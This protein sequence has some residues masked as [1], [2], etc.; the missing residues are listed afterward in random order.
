M[1]T[2]LRENGFRLQVVYRKGGAY[3]AAAHDIEGKLAQRFG[4]A[5]KELG[6]R[7]L[8]LMRDHYAVHEITETARIQ[9][10]DVLSGDDAFQKA[11]ETLPGGEPATAT[12]QAGPA[13]PEQ[14]QPHFEA[15]DGPVLARLAS[16]AGNRAISRLLARQPAPGADRPSGRPKTPETVKVKM[17]WDKT[18]PPQE[19]LK[20]AF[21]GHPVDWKAEVLRRRQE[22]RQ[23]RRLARGRP[24]QGLQAHVR[25]VPTPRRSKDLDYYD[26]QDRRDQEGGRRRLR[27]PARLQPREPVL[28]RRELGE[29]RHRPRQGR[30]RSSRRRCSG[31]NDPGQRAGRPDGQR[32]QRV[33]QRRA[34]SPTTSEGEVTDSLVS[35]GG[36]NRRTTSAGSF[37]NHSTGCA[38]DINENLA[39]YQNMHFKA[40]EDGKANKPHVQAMELIARGR[41]AR[42]GLELLGP[43]GRD[44]LRRSGSRPPTSSTS[45]SRSSCPSCSTTRSAAPPTRAS[46]SSA[47]RSTGSAA[48]RRWASSWSPTQDPKKLARRR[49]GGQEGRRRPRPPSG[50]S[51][52]PATGP[53]VRAWIEGVV[54]YK[55][56]DAWSLHVG[57]REARRGRQGEARRQGRA[58]RHHPAAPEARRDARGG[59]LDLADRPDRGQGLHALRGPGRVRGAQ[60]VVA[61][62]ALLRRGALTWSSRATT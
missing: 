15:L 7:L 20:D 3:D 19:Y 11:L 18:E 54:M 5:G 30:A 53:Q 41:Q 61:A 16:Y 12:A 33:L 17:R 62:R 52:S 31:K 27:R 57:A 4:A 50:S 14:E 26:G 44:G 42:V 48:P 24:G 10:M 2:W 46:P 9:H 25:V 23:R 34:S 58:A 28:H 55:G 51:A 60:A 40:K 37:S 13:Q 21:T 56:K 8:Q 59:R 22:R 36:Y 32:D 38:V 47:R 39:T 45:T 49:Q 35:I 6:P 29:G 1:E 43:V